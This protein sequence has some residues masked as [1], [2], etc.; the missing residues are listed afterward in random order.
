M[1][2][3]FNTKTVIALDAEKYKRLKGV[4][5]EEGY[6]FSGWVRRQIDLFLL[7][8]ELRGDRVRGRLSQ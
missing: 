8:R 5:R 3:P 2:D 4:L 1:Q 6:T 7:D